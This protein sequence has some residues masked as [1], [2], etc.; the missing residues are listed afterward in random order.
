MGSAVTPTNVKGSSALTPK[1]RLASR[2]VTIPAATN[3]I[4]TPI[5]TSSAPCP[6]ISR[7]TSRRSAPSAI[8]TP[9]SRVR[10]A[11]A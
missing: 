6:T 5:P 3:P 7:K 2:R 4:A 11:T 10:A 9:I 1:R 8:R